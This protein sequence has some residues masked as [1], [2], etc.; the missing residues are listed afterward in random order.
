MESTRLPDIYWNSTNPIFR[1]DN[2]DHI[3]DVNRN[4]NNPFE[5]DQVNLIC[6]NYSKGTRADQETYIIYNVSKDEYDQC[7]IN[8]NSSKVIANCNKPFDKRYFTITF[9]SFTPQPGGLEFHPGK[10]YYF[11]STSTGTSDGLERKVGGRCASHHMKITFRVCCGN[12]NDGQSNRNTLQQQRPTSKQ[13]ATPPSNV[14][15][16]TNNLDDSQLNPMQSLFKKLSA[17]DTQTSDQQQ[18]NQIPSTGHHNLQFDT[19][20]N[21]AL[22]NGVLNNR[23]NYISSTMMPSV[24]VNTPYWWRPHLSKLPTL[25]HQ[26]LIPS[27]EVGSPSSSHNM[28]NNNLNQF[29]PL[30]SLNNQQ[31]PGSK[32]DVWMVITGGCIAVLVAFVIVGSLFACTNYLFFPAKRKSSSPCT[33]LQTQTLHSPAFA[34]G[35]LAQ[36]GLHHTQHH[37]EY[38]MQH[39]IIK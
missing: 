27:A 39:T 36:Y 30:N 28:N 24:P 4:Q 32:S 12:N 7:R 14:D 31:Q 38:P 8:S 15:R 37:F 10:D 18:N 16:L 3:I 26:S 11:I 5:Y 29:T 34:Q 9:R 1:P 35:T 33:T 20:K 19:D 13:E 17:T 6:P 21:T 25:K 2:M 23:P 22:H